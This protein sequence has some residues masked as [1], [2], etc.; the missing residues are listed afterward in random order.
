MP[1]QVPRG[2]L[3]CPTGVQVPGKLPLHAPQAPHD[4]A[5][6]QTPSVQKLPLAH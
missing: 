4:D 6:Q 5:P 2:A 1:P 3:S